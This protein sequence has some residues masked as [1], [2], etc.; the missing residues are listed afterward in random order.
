MKAYKS[1]LNSE[2]FNHKVHA[3]L[4]IIDDILIKVLKFKSLLTYFS[5]EWFL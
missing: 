1:S 4:T 3:L 5:L 2:K